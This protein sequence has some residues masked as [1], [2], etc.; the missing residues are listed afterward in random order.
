VIGSNLPMVTA[1]RRLN[2]KNL[3]NLT[4]HPLYSGFHYDHPT[5]IE[6]ETSLKS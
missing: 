4:P 5:L 3:S 6:R 1:L 2:E